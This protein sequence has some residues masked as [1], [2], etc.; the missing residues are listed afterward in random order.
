MVWVPVAD[1]ML[2]PSFVPVSNP[3]DTGRK[4]VAERR[5][6]VN[7]FLTWL[8]VLDIGVLLKDDRI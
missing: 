6:L 8:G 7:F 2:T 1:E 3:S 5:G 4:I